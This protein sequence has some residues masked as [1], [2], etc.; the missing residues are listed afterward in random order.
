MGD[1][2]AEPSEVLW[3]GFP[4][5][6]KVD[7]VILRRAFSPFGE[8]EKI[9]AFPGRSYAFVRF[10]NIMAA[11]R[12]KETLQGKLFGNPR[13]HICFARSEFATASSGRNS[14]NAPPSPNFRSYG[15]PGSSENFQPDR[16]F[17]NMPGDPGMRSPRFI[18]K[19]ENESSLWGTG[20]A[21]FEPGRF[22]DM[23]PELG[24][25][26]SMYENRRSPPRERGIRFREF[27]PQQFA[28]QGPFDDDAWDLPEEALLF[29]G[30]KKLKTNSFPPETELPEYPFSEAEQVKRVLPRV[31][32][33]PQHENFDSGPFGYKQMPDHAMN[34][35]QSRGDH[36]NAPYDSFQAN[37]ASL[38]SN[39]I[40]WKRST[41]ELQE[42]SP[43]KEWKW[44]G[45]I[46]KGGTPVC[47][48]RC[49][50]VGKVLDMIL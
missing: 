12:A 17:G 6:L 8:I 32:D 13:V 5:L 23:G 3:I 43:N 7:E 50:P 15:R 1:K 30:A 11:C 40:E 10:K 49:F 21:A 26:G 20:N 28:R 9:T 39:P 16:Y 38:P 37:S 24:L 42:S 25:Q 29:H 48:A 4:A 33:F 14:L 47:R 36:W 27:S 46:A 2:N 19:L 45:T 44:E 41:P 22:Q 34:S 35:A 31:P 18:P